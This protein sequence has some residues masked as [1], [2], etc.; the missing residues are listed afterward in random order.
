MNHYKNCLILLAAALVAGCEGTRSISNSGYHEP[1][2][3]LFA[4]PHV[5]DTDPAFAY[6]G[7]LNEFDV[8]G[9]ARG[10]TISDADIEHAL[11]TAKRVRLRPG[12]SVLLIQSGAQFPDGPMVAELSK[13]YRVVPFSGVPPTAR[14]ARTPGLQD[15]AARGY[16]QSLR[17]AAARGGNDI[18]VCYWGILESQNSK[19]ATKTISWVPVVNWMVP[20]EREHMRLR[21]KMAVMDVRTGDWAVLSPEP[22]DD[23]AMSVSPRRGAADQKLVEKLKQRAYTA[24]ARELVRQYSDAVVQN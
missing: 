13:N 24:A 23:A 12:S 19:L 14:M 7:E 9:I 5:P 20:D 4:R 10:A 3:S 1:D 6:R 21:L 15:E 8:L 16:S 11:N 18:I 2:E 22:V 17:L